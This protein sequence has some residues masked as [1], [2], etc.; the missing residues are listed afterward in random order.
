MRIWDLPV[1]V[2]CRQHLLGE[3]RELHA[4]WSILVNDK[5]GYRNHPETR[6]WEGKLPMLWLR[7]ELQVKEMAARG[8]N[9]AS[10]LSHHPTGTPRAFMVSP[11]NTLEEQITLLR[12]K[13]CA[14]KVVSAVD[15][16]AAIAAVEGRT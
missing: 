6:R 10:P 15:R 13:G 1:E 5:Q 4:I 8:Y 16:L 14:C 12:A 11:I 3:H 2:L 7:H 9:H